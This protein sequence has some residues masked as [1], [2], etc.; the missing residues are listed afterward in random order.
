MGRK[1]Y[2]TQSGERMI[3]ALRRIPFRPFPT[4]TLIIFTFSRLR[5]IFA[6]RASCT[7]VPLIRLRRAFDGLAHTFSS[8]LID[9]LRNAST[10][11]TRRT[12]CFL[13]M[14]QGT[15]AKCSPGSGGEEVLWSSLLEPPVR[16]DPR[17]ES[18]ER[19]VDVLGFPLRNGFPCQRLS[20]SLLPSFRRSVF[21]F[22]EHVFS[23][24]G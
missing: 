14:S 24:S 8:L 7:F 21:L 3:F 13:F 15:A 12:A 9:A 2:C 19:V 6:A 11:A 5:L 18:L 4:P 22:A 17:T 20:S 23:S 10:R 16:R 1:F